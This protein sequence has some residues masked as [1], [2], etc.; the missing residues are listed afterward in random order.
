MFKYY[1]PNLILSYRSYTVERLCTLYAS[2][3]LHAQ[4]IRRWV[5]FDKLEVVCK[6]PLLIYGESLK[7]FL[8]ARN[9]GHKKTLKIDQLK[10]VKCKGFFTPKDKIITLYR[11]KNGSLRATGYCTPCNHPSSRFY[12]KSDEPT[13]RKLFKV[14][15]PQVTTICYSLDTDSKAHMKRECRDRGNESIKVSGKSNKTV[16]GTVKG[17]PEQ[18][19]LL[20]VVDET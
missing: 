3:K 2:K 1:N 5:K 14:N 11:N 17:M 10:C 7:A 9:E 18:L 12:K 13:L 15:D 16:E 19:S 20:S 6:K 4:T 8:Y